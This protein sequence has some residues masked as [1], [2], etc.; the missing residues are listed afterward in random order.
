MVGSRIAKALSQSPIPPAQSSTSKSFFSVTESQKITHKRPLIIG[1]S[2]LDITSKLDRH[3]QTE[4]LIGDK[5]PGKI[6]ETLGGVGRN[7]AEACHRTGGN[8]LF[9][10][11]VGDDLLG[12]S[13][14]KATSE[15]NMVRSSG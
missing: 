5:H 12:T 9:L 7:I 6:I 1:G 8:P 2:V 10:S 3:I 13:I 14:L 4:A 15:M 11:V